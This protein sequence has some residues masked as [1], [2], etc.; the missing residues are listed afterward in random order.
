MEPREL[1]DAKTPV[2]KTNSQYQDISSAVVHKQPYR[3]DEES[4]NKTW[5][6]LQSM[7]DV[8]ERRGIRFEAQALLK[9]IKMQ[10]TSASLGGYVNHVGH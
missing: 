1:N 6:S 9:V 7:T 3:G 8:D 4:P 2:M 10:R 5:Q